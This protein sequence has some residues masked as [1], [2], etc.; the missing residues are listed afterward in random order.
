M[1]DFPRWKI[2]TILTVCLFFIYTALPNVLTPEQRPEW[3]GSTVNLGLDLRG[4]VHLLYELDFDNYIK[5]HMENLRSD[6]RAALREEGIGYLDI[7]NTGESIRFTLRRD[8]LEGRSLQTIM[9]KLDQGL[10]VEEDGDTIR[11]SY[12]SQAIKKRRTEL[13]EQSI[14]IVNRRVNETGTTEPIIQRQGDN[15]IIVQVPGLDDPQ[16]LKDVVGKTAKMTFHLVNV[17]VTEEQAQAGNVPLG[18]RVVPGDERQVLKDGTPYKY[19]I[20]S[21][22]ELSGEMLTGANAT[23][24]QGQPV[25]AF[26]FDTKGARKFAEITKKNVGHPFAVVLDGRVVTAPNIRTPILDGRGIIEGNFTVESANTLALLLRAGALP[27]PLEIVEERTVGPSLGS[28]S[29]A[30]GQAAAVIA[31]IIVMVFMLVSYGL[32]GIFSNIALIMNMVMLLGALSLLQA[33]LTLPGIAGI[34]L[35]L[36]MAVDANVLIFERIRE[37]ITRGRTTFSAVENGFKAA[38]HTIIDSNLTTLIA[39]SILFAFGTGTIKGFAVTL[40]LGILSSMFTAIMLTRM[41]VVIWLKRVRPKALP[42]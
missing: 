21:K 22:V 1:L 37:E 36:G 33:T 15:R 12:S 7:T 26:S 17:N 3:L 11:V 23:Y 32:F 13:L 4:G 28:D 5:E 27:A 30:A 8:T 10:E 20:Y 18:T 19:A 9:W 40:A 41:M 35:T 34:V 16:V 14:E 24:Q 6:V 42:I 31:I 39:A 25:V 38:F 29:I 2:I